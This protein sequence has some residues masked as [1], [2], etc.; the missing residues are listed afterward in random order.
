[1]AYGIYNLTNSKYR[2]VQ[3]AIM[4]GMDMYMDIIK[5]SVSTRNVT[6][7]GADNVKMEKEKHNNEI[8]LNCN[9]GVGDC[10]HTPTQSERYFHI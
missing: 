5:E 9:Y 2:P 7:D 10:V 1:M 3:K 6:D 8:K 4:G